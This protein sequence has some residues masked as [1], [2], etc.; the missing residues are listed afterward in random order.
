M[1]NTLSTARLLPVLV[2]ALCGGCSQVIES[3]AIEI[4]AN[5]GL[6]CHSALGYYL[7][8]RTL[9]NVVATSTPP[10]TSAAPAATTA[11]VLTAAPLSTNAPTVTLSVSALT[12]ADRRQAFCLDY[13]GL[14]T[15]DD[16]VTAQRDPQN[17]GLLTSVSSNVTDQTP[18]IALNLI[19]T[20]E[21][22]AL[23][24][25]RD[26]KLAPPP[27]STPDTVAMQFDPFNWDDLMTAKVALRR[28]G[29]CLYVEGFSFSTAGLS[30]SGIREA[31]DRWCSTDAGH[32]PPYES[33]LYTL[34]MSPVSPEAMRTGILYRPK[35]AYK[36]VILRKADPTDPNNRRA[37][38]MLFQTVR[39][40]M[41][42][43]SPVLS[44]GIER[45]AF[46]N[47]KTTVN[48]DPPGTLTDV[49]VDKESEAAGFVVI[50][51]S[52][53]QAIVDV[54]AQILKLRI[55]DTQ[56]QAALLQAQGELF[57]AM[58]DYAKLVG[59]QSSGLPG[60]GSLR[61]T[62]S[63]QQAVSNCLNGNGDPTYCY[64][65]GTRPQ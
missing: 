26:A 46:A 55:A 49:A 18:Q 53:A 11:T 16:K 41:V 47:R 40:E 24:A 7:L 12:S 37:P 9:L 45:A 1:R 63:P 32:T 20:A 58:S 61:S 51:L 21:N 52:I 25:A 60:N 39:V 36:V 48:F 17:M 10:T 38:W 43:A 6:L 13:L 35:M 5:P 31:S 30:A 50:P 4:G 56:N 34:A 42:N 2:A 15:S 19:Q 62:T 57:Q 54:P 14:V 23:A 27:G 28:F 59:P 33:P 22:L 64:S 29:F 3:S 65:L 8:P 44:I